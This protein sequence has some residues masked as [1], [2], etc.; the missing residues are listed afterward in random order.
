MDNLVDLVPTSFVYVFFRLPRCP[1]DT[2]DVH[3]IRSFALCYW[4]QVCLEECRAVVKNLH[5]SHTTY[6]G[7]LR[8]HNHGSQ[9]IKYLVHSWNLTVI[10]GFRLFQNL[11]ARYQGFLRVHNHDSQ[12]TKYLV[13]SWNIMVVQ[14]FRL[15][16]KSDW[17]WGFFDSRF[18]LIPNIDCY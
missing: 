3:P 11:S 10:K 14:G 16:I 6:Q 12:K 17:N 4:W 2:D 7:F 9:Q 8:V 18:F 5:Q 13:H 1:L 15:F